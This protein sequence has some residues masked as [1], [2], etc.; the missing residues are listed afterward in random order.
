MRFLVQTRVVNT[1]DFFMDPNENNVDMLTGVAP[2]REP[3]FDGTTS[4]Y[5]KFPESDFI[6]PEAR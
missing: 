6:P 2:A 5:L 1:Q 4:Q 3:S